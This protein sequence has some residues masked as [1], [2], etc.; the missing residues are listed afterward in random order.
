MF[1]STS[2]EVQ[3]RAKHRTFT[4][5]EKAR[6]LAAYD[7]A[8][9]ALEHA[10]LMRREG[11]VALELAQAAGAGRC[12]KEAR[13]PGQSRGRRSGSPPKGARTIATALGEIGTHGGRLGESARTLADD[14]RREQRGRRAVEGVVRELAQ[15]IGERAACRHLGAARAT[16]QRRETPPAPASR[17]LGMV[18]RRLGDDER[19]AILDA[20][21]SE[22]F[23]DLNARE[24][25]ATLL[26]EGRYLGSISTWY[27]VLRAA[28]ETRERRR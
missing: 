18:P 2:P 23:A 1:T 3:S 14:R 12:P 13:A 6:I 9:S 25:Y 26:D 10:A 27:R 17:R 28:G 22:R 4:A 24:I 15:Q 19:Q 5:D 8:A 21:H 16:M 11:V 7:A 20:A